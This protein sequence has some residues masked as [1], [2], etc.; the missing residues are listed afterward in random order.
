MKLYIATIFLPLSPD[1]G[2]FLPSDGG[3]LPER[4]RPACSPLFGK[5]NLSSY[6]VT[7]SCKSVTG[8]VK[9]GV[10]SSNREIALLVINFF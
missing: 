2:F 10:Q 5:K 6:L 4:L 8:I 3:S 9:S 1:T 7:N